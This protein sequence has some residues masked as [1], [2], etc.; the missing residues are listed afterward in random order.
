MAWL[1]CL[2]AFQ[3]LQLPLLLLLRTQPLA[4]SL[5]WRWTWW[6]TWSFGLNFWY[7]SH[8]QSTLIPLILY[9]IVLFISRKSCEWRVL[10]GLKR[11][12]IVVEY[13]CHS[14]DIQVFLSHCGPSGFIV[15]FYLC[16]LWSLRSLHFKFHWFRHDSHDVVLQ[17]CRF[18]GG[19][20]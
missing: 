1:I 15:D 3:N 5:K 8:L 10:D 6:L 4:L 11:L 19:R 9:V 17:I 7:S 20:F 18:V 2:Q 16:S 12:K 13:Q 14:E